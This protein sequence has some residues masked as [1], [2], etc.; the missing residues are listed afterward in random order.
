MAKSKIIFSNGEELILNEGDVLV[1]VNSYKFNE[2][3]I[4]SMN[5][6]TILES[7][8]HDGLIPSILKVVLNNPYFYGPDGIDTIYNSAS[9]VK[10]EN[11]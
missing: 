2:E 8:F 1:S 9:I 6:S 7:T 11:I 3:F 4:P 10:I 5:A